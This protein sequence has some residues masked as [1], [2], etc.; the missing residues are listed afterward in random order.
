MPS[1]LT[2][3]QRNRLMRK[4]YH[5]EK[6]RGTISLKKQWQYMFIGNLPFEQL[7]KVYGVTYQKL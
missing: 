7:C 4:K 6:R 2:K 5:D 1:T 3:I